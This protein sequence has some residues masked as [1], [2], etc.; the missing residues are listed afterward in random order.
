MTNQAVSGAEQLALPSSTHGPLKGLRVLELGSTVAGPFCGRLLADFGAEV[1]K[2]EAPEGD[3]LRTMGEHVDGK[4]LY[5]A[6]I[7]RNKSLLTLDLRSNSGRAL[8]R[9]LALVSDIV[10]ENFRPGTLEK[11]G[12][13]YASL[14]AANPGL[15]MVR[16]SGYG[17]SGP[18][19]D[20]PGYGVIGEAMSGVRHLT[21]DP[22]RAPARAGVSMTDYLTGLYGAFGAVMAVLSRNTTGRGQVVDAALYESAFSM[23][24][25][26]VPA[27][28]KV[29]KVPVRT[30][31]KL[32]GSTPNN[33]YLTADGH[34]IHVAAMADAVFRRLAQAIGA[35]ELGTHPDYV[36]A[37]ARLTNEVALND[38]ISTWCLQHALNHIEET[39]HRLDV[40]ASRIYTLVDIFND[41]H[42]QARDMLVSVDDDALGRVILP[43]V[44]PALS[45][46]PGE[47]R[48][49]GRQPGN[50]SRAVLSSWLG[51]AH[52]QI[53]ALIADGV[54]RECV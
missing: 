3:A 49:A 5:A 39:L 42:Y 25:P 33:L 14:S 35:P 20:R 6:S 37:A 22:D 1:V 32:P 16:I 48:H 47:I 46:T 43:G 11:W 10:V 28:D 17:Q 36:T 30:G 38:L 23:M 19:R 34:Y 44:V 26:F 52:A 53:D 24:E 21:G 51:M 29:G 45:D 54:V 4:S 2:V 15:I 7:L 31:S 9:E 40:P 27:F 12:L 13:D 50:D 18:Y 8:A 41:A